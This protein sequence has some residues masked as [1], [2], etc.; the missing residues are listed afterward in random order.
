M[1]DTEA[2]VEEIRKL[3]K[4]SSSSC[5]HDA[6]GGM[7]CGVCRQVTLLNAYDEACRQRDAIMRERDESRKVHPT[8][9]WAQKQRMRADKRGRD[10]AAVAL[11]LGQWSD[12]F[13]HS[14]KLAGLRVKDIDP[15]YDD[16]S[17]V[18]RGTFP[19]WLVALV[20]KLVAQRDAERERAEGAERAIFLE[21]EVTDNGGHWCWE[22]CGQK[23]VL[24]DNACPIC[25]RV[26]EKESHE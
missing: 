4:A 26:L 22:V 5:A 8:W 20:E 23:H 6:P 7:G 24:S 14:L 9:R 21:H 10:L 3:L 13:W 2:R 12:A 19:R 25:V 16:Y 11:K 15:E 1:T 18:P 17:G